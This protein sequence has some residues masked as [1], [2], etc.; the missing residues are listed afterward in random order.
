MLPGA[1]LH[2]VGALPD[3]CDRSRP[4]LA[5]RDATSS[6]PSDPELLTVS[7]KHFEITIFHR[8]GLDGATI[9]G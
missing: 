1:R 9:A 4:K 6:R 7:V 2:A 5:G 8:S 3:S